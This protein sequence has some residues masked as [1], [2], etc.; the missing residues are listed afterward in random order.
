M[1]DLE[2]IGKCVEHAIDALIRTHFAITTH[3]VRQ[4][5]HTESLEFPNRLRDVVKA[6][7]PLLETII[8]AVQHFGDGRRKECTTQTI[9]QEPTRKVFLPA[10]S[11]RASLL[12]SVTV[13]SALPKFPYPMYCIKVL[14]FAVFL[15]EIKNANSSGASP[16]GP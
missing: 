11:K 14:D 2:E 15:M 12:N 16:N 8:Q 13:D 3:L 9:L 4:G 6:L 7:Q 1:P 10:K 5:Q